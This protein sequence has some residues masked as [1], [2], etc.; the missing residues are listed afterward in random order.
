MNGGRRKQ[1]TKEKQANEW[2]AGYKKA[3]C[4]RNVK[5]YEK[6]RLKKDIKKNSRVQI[7]QKKREV[8]ET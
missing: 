8:G 3:K 5:R 4:L 2:N 7:I 6:E 1:G